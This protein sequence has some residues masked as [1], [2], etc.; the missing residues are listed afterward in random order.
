MLNRLSTRFAS[1]LQKKSSISFPRVRASLRYETL[2]TMAQA[3]HEQ[4]QEPPVLPITLETMK[5]AYEQ[6]CAGE[7]PWTAL[8]NFTNAWFGYAK[9]LRTDLVSEPL[10]MPE[11]ETE[12]TRRWAAFC[13]ASVEL[14]CDRYHVSCPNWVD[15]PSYLLETPWWRTRQVHDSAVR[16]RL[17]QTT[18]VSFARRNI[19][20]NHRLFQNKYEMYEWTQEAMNEGITSPA[21][22]HRYVH[23][24][25]ISIHGA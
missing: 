1:F 11:Q 13:A 10:V 22:I 23:Q 21:E 19:F 25:E 18:P 7:D 3:Y 17:V 9:H 24:K 2:R 20:C 15:N 14:L 12:H 6:I 4:K 5:W 16:E 8:G